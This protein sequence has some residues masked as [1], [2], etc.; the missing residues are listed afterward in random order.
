MAVP[1]RF[2]SEFRVNSTTTG[3]QEDSSIAALAN[4]KFV[5]VWSDAPSADIKAQIFNADGSPFGF[6]FNVADDP[7]PGRSRP[8]VTATADGRFVVAWEETPVGGHSQISARVLNSDGTLPSGDY[9]NI[10][11][12]STVTNIHQTDAAIAAGS[13]GRF[14]VSWT[15]QSNADV[16]AR[17]Y[18]A[19]GPWTTNEYPVDGGPA[20]E[21]ATAVAGLG[22]GNYIMV[23]NDSGS[24]G[25]TD[26]SGYH[27]RARIF[28]GKGEA[29]S[30]QSEFQV[31]LN[32]VI[33]DQTDPSVVGLSDGGFVVVYRSGDGLSFSHGT[34]AG[35][36]DASGGIASSA[37]AQGQPSVTATA[38]GFLVAWS[39]TVPGG[40][41]PGTFVRAQLFNN[42]GSQASD[43]FIVNASFPAWVSYQPRVANLADGRFVISWTDPG[44]SPA[45]GD[46]SGSSVSAQIY[47]PRTAGVNLAG[48]IFGDDWVGTAFEDTMN[49]QTGNDTLAGA[50]GSD[51][52]NGGAGLDRLI[53]GDGNDTYYV[54][55]ID[56]IISETNANAPIGGYDIVVYSGG[57]DT[58]IL[59]ANLESL[60]LTNATLNVN[61]T[62]NGL[63]NTLLGSN[64]ANI[65]VGLGGDDNLTGGLGKD[66]L[67]GGGGNDIYYVERNDEVISETNPNAATGGIDSVFYSGDGTFFLGANLERLRLT[68]T[69]FTVNGI[70]N[71][72]DNEITGSTTDNTLVGYGGNDVLN[73]GAGNDILLGGVGNDTYIVDAAGDVTFES[74]NAGIDTIMSA[75]TRKLGANFEKLTLTGLDAVN[76]TGN[77]LANVV[78]GNAAQNSLAGGGGNDKL[79]GDAGQDTLLGGSGNDT[80][81]G[82]IGRDFL[83][84][85]S[86]KDRFDFNSASEIGKTASTRDIIRDFVHGTDK[87]DLATI[88]ANG[89]ASGNGKFKFVAS[90]SAAFT[91]VRG[92]LIWDQKNNSGSANDKTIVSGDINGDGRADFTIELTG[93][94]AL[95]AG[96]FVL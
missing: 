41:S 54:E 36:I 92:Q 72:L 67:I 89:S 83:T 71:G 31:N 74:A 53:G 70:G 90:E 2:G 51:Q 9:E 23:W 30:G 33:G 24:P 93:L 52:L 7:I 60:S 73:G 1:A 62:G 6:E 64:S 42:N 10:L 85:G 22:D 3:I 19:A 11:T 69:T 68:N 28:S 4:G 49:G 78:V 20:I 35:N 44:N 37:G 55:R 95:T 58:F 82:G 76:G 40:E 91:D 25:E 79:K 32:D 47:D 16:V 66:T 29:I 39:E 87:I 8:V 96:D 38:T 13:S 18:N 77:K 26:N 94:K 56:E 45:Q 46:G 34:A 59:G 84:G 88:D 14:F 63:G 75:V 61:G 80:L 15:A 17:A 81:T 65:L 12:V 21:G 86:G 43:Q 27:I 5:V 57:G 50:G 48:T